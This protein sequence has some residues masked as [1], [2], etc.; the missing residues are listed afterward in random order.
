[1]KFITAVTFLFITLNTFSQNKM[2]PVN[3]LT[4]NKNLGWKDIQ[5]W[6]A[7]ATNK[8]EIL[9]AD[10]QKAKDAL[11][12]T[13]VTTDS[14]M[15]AVVYKTGG[16]LVDDG[17]IRI[18]G[19]G[20]AKLDR[21]LPGWNK[22]K[23]FKEFGEKPAFLL[24]ADDALGGFF[25]LNGGALGTDLG[26][27]YYLSPD[28]LQYEA[29]DISYSEFLLFCFNNDLNKFYEGSR[30]E[31]WRE[32]VSKLNGDKVFNFY[33]FLWTEEGQDINKTSRKIIPVE[34]QYGFNIDIRK[35]MGL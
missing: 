16:I 15:G 26:K 3:E 13:Q 28:N 10:P 11:Y 27:M 9:P 35:Q 2:R 1:M 18:L 17:W 22:G 25:I 6:S 5:E 33:P 21:S 29:L 30:W 34:E 14:A 20:N 12:Q 7:K 23:S 4:N 32:E 24:V 8:L 31:K 19:S